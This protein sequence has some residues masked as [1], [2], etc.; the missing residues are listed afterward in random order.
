MSNTTEP[1]KATEYTISIPARLLP[2]DVSRRLDAYFAD[3]SDV[4]EAEERG[5]NVGDAQEGLDDEARDLLSLLAN[6]LPR[7]RP[8]VSPLVDGEKTEGSVSVRVDEVT[9]TSGLYL[10]PERLPADYDRDEDNR[11]LIDAAIADAVSVGMGITD[12]WERTITETGTY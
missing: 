10:H 8:E 1:E 2:S 11:R 12:V 5:E 4:A 7:S 9:T 6:I 3:L